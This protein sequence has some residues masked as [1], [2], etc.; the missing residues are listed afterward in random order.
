[1]IVRPL[2]DS[3]RRLAVRA[4]WQFA[5]FG[6]SRPLAVRAVWQFAPVGR[7]R[8]LAVRARWPFAPV[9]RSRPLAVRALWYVALFATSL[10]SCATAPRAGPL[11]G[12]PVAAGVPDTRLPP[13]Y[14]RLIFGWE[15]KE[16][17]FSA[18]GDGVARIA[19]PDSVRIDLFLENGNSGGYVILIGDSLTALAQ[20]EA[21][22]SLPP[23]P[24]LWAALGVVRVTAP[25]TTARQDGDTLRVEVG[26]NPTWRMAFG[27]RTL[28]RMEQIVGGR[29]EQVVERR[30]S[31]R[32]VYRQPAAGRS[33]VLTMRRSIPE[34]G[35]DA[36]IWRP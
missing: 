33:L 6:S 22:R 17:M 7:S 10:T 1:M 18:R 30:D 5:P 20:D 15:Y 3:A 27:S 36:A 25:D 34:S 11:T 4:V 8:L 14:R 13:G 19:P 26:S 29:I 32:V 2:L 21:R 16:R 31:T 12:V 23:E 28:G 35:F 24:L 9:G